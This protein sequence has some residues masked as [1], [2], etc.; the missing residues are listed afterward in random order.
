MH[1]MK[2]DTFSVKTDPKTGLKFVTKQ[3][4]EMMKNHRA[5]DKE[6]VSGIMPASQGSEFCPVASYELYVSKLNPENDSLWQRSVASFVED[7]PIWYCNSPVGVK[8]MGTFMSDLSK[9]CDLSQIYTNH[10]VRATGSTILSKGMYSPAQIMSV[11][12]H[13]SVQ[14]LTV[15]QRVDDEEKIRMEQTIT[16]SMQPAK[17]NQLALL[18]ASNRPALPAPSYRLAL[19]GPS[20]PPIGHVTHLAIAPTQNHEQSVVVTFLN[21]SDIF[22]DFSDISSVSNSVSNT[23]SN[24]NTCNNCHITVIQNLTINK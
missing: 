4:D 20:N 10:S 12:G 21:L 6:N 7:E 5:N 19:P 22:S 1:L 23:Q 13:K 17:S 18:A 2:K 3:I 8:K 24:P 15:Y 9:L 16:E 11:T 14:S